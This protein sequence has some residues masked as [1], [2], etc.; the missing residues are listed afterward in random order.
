M[1]RKHSG[2]DAIKLKKMDS[3]Y[4]R[5]EELFNQLGLPSDTCSIKFFITQNSPLNNCLRLEDAPCWTSSQATFLKENIQLDSNWAGV[6]DQLNLAM[7]VEAFVQR[8][9][10]S[11]NPGRF[12]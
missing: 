9:G 7:H 2:T 3:T 11:S 5:F 6:V 10:G 8:L 12:I 4:H 1:K